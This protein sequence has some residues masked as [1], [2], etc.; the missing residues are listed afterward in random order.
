MR[1]LPQLRYD[2][3]RFLFGFL[4]AVCLKILFAFI[5]GNITI[6][7]WPLK[8]KFS[9]FAE[10][11]GWYF[12]CKSLAFNPIFSLC[13]CYC[14]FRAQ[15]VIFRILW[16]YVFWDCIRWKHSQRMSYIFFCNWNY[17]WVQTISTI[18][19]LFLMFHGLSDW[20]VST[21]GHF[22]CC[23][24]NSIKPVTAGAGSTASLGQKFAQPSN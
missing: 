14:F 6:L 11:K 21:V 5:H 17:S 1:Q 8:L 12:G 9:F 2:L 3:D 24:H 10:P 15:W 16:Y 20:I 23:E 7:F 13:D 18:E 19:L 22:K 4:Q